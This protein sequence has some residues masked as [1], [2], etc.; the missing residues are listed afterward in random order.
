MEWKKS[1]GEASAK[2]FTK[3]SNDRDKNDYFVIAYSY[4]SQPFESDSIKYLKTLVAIHV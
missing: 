1:Y 4:I 3:F 2:K